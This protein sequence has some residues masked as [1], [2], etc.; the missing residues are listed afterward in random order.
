MC[1]FCFRPDLHL[2]LMRT[3]ILL[4]EL[5]NNDKIKLLHSVLDSTPCASFSPQNVQSSPENLF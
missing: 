1:S 2:Y 3:F 4:E 5:N